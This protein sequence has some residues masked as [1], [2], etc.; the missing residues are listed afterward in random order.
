MTDN[1]RCVLAVILIVLVCSIIDSLSL[2]FVQTAFAVPTLSASPASGYPNSTI[3]IVGTGFSVGTGYVW[4]DKD[5]G[6]DGLLLPG[7]PFQIITTTDGTFTTTLVVPDLN[8][9]QQSDPFGYNY[10]HNFIRA[11]FPPVG[12][13]PGGNGFLD[14]NTIFTI[15]SPPQISINDVS[16]FEGNSSLTSFVFTVTSNPPPNTPITLDFA[17]ADGAA[18]VGDSDYNQNSGT[19]TLTSSNPSQSIIVGVVGDTKVEPDETFY[20]NLSNPTVGL[21]TRNQGIGTVLNDDAASSN[22]PPSVSAGSDQTITLPIS[23]SLSGVVADDGLPTGSILAITWSKVSGPGTISFSSPNSATDAS[24]SEPGTYQLRLFADDSELSASDDVTITV[25]PVDPPAVVDTDNDG[26]PDQYD[27][28]P[29]DPLKITPGAGGCGVPEPDFSQIISGLQ[30][31]I[32]GLNSQILQLQED[33]A[34]A[35]PEYCGIE[36]NSWP[37]VIRGTQGDDKL[38]G[39]SNDDLILGYDGN[40][41][42]YGGNG[43]DCIVTGNGNSLILGGNG[44]DIIMTGNGT[45][46]IYGGSGNDW[47]RAGSGDDLIFA[48]PGDDY[49]DGGNGTDRC[50]GGFGNDT[51]ISCEELIKNPKNENEESNIEHP[52]H[53]HN[54]KV[55]DQNKPNDKKFGN[56]NEKRKR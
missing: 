22:Q 8:P 25:N 28:C 30:D 45:N 21:I 19:I 12:S 24:F 13:P 10:R 43:N 39:T 42:I 34:A 38:V 26:V 56:D 9:A 7:D 14:R 15:L 44:D 41:K 54:D 23:A 32:L 11:D 31:T 53:N 33:L 17:T 5:Y 48:G 52:N 6:E 49:V 36:Q 40:N 51:V 47:I 18:T 50:N 37:V 35:N 20:V 2:G 27:Q 1:T 4:F 46:R 16:S 3:T 29:L 55:S